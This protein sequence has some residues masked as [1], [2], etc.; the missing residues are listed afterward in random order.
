MERLTDPQD[1]CDGNWP[2]RLDL[3][4]VTGREAKGNHVFLREAAFLPQLLYALAKVTKEFL[5]VRHV[6]FYRGHEQKYHEQISVYCGIMKFSSRYYRW[7]VE[8]N[9]TE[10]AGSKSTGEGA[11][12]TQLKELKRAAPDASTP[13]EP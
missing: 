10:K 11:C 8:G 9:N 1:C 4:P 5:G 12:A 6:S 13:S 2:P 3:L 7:D